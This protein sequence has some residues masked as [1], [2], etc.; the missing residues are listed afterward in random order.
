MNKED[1]TEGAVLSSLEELGAMQ[2]GLVTTGQAK[3]IGIERLWLSRLM[4]RGT[5]HR[6]RHGVYALP[7]ATYG[8]HQ[9]L[10][11]AWLATDRA[12]TLEE[13]VTDN[14]HVVVSHISASNLH[15]L[16]DL[17]ATRHDFSSAQRRQTAQED[18]HFYRRQL[19]SDDVVLKDGLPVTSVPR[20]IADLAE[21]RVDFD[22]LAQ[23]VK[24]ALS[25]GLADFELLTSRL[26]FTARA[27]GYGS[28]G[29]F[30][31]ALIA[32]AGL[33]AGV[34]SL[35]SRT[36]SS[37]LGESLSRSTN[38]IGKLQ[39]GFDVNARLISRAYENLLASAVSKMVAEQFRKIDFSSFV[40]QIDWSQHLGNLTSEI[41]AF[42]KTTSPLMGSAHQLGHNKPPE[43]A[44]EIEQR[45]EDPGEA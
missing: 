32:E 4:D 29:E 3:Q 34:Q 27:Y 2:W 1:L 14:N 11:A 15:G 28:G 7:S 22:Q 45:E 9:E 13:R 42:P 18:V 21:I 23:V 19:A 43:D 44:K 38:E 24:D 39:T 37:A 26:D 25:Q 40:K 36:I 17:V 5:I 31:D 30:M 6:V 16:G 20:T 33:P 41:A 8:P 12:R 35:L 10:Q